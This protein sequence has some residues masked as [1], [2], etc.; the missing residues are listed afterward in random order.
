MFVFSH[1]FSALFNN[2]AQFITSFASIVVSH[3][4]LK[5]VSALGLRSQPAPA[6]MGI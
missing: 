3:P 4:G 2:T 5:P 1:F 6:Q